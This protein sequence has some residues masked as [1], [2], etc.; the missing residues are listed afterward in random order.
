ME[1]II[2]NVTIKT[3]PEIATEWI[4]WMREEHI[5]DLMKTGLFTG[6]RLCHLLEQDEADGI[7][8]TVQYYCSSM[9]DYQTYID[10]YAPTM[11]EKA[12]AR[13]GNRFMAFRTV[14]EEL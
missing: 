6:Y 3:E 7:T 4:A 12:F 2:Y 1:M 9:E 13:F 5:P 14:M 8:F 10:E 11:R